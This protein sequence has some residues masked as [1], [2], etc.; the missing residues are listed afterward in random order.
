MLIPALRYRDCDAALTF[1]TGV[2]GLA[3]HAVFRDNRGK[4]QHAQLTHGSGMVMIG[5]DAATEFGALMIHPDETQGRATVSIYAVVQDVAARH[6]RA[7]AAGAEIVIPLQ[8]EAYGGESFSLRD[9]EGH[10][11][12]IGSYDPLAPMTKVD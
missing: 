4:V 7:V 6:A 1:L 10:V 9:T 5:P 2:L 3:E 12:S 8:A 11:W